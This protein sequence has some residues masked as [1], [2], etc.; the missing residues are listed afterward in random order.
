MGGK[1]LETILLIC[2]V[3]QTPVIIR[4]HAATL[5]KYQWLRP[6]GSE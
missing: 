3:E 2:S 5:G 6:S 1:D 4:E